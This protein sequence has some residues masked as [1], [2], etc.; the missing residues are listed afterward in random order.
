MTIDEVRKKLEEFPGDYK[1]A[2]IRDED[3]MVFIPNSI[4]CEDESKTVWM[5]ISEY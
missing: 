2:C 4:E 3:C 5:E 1:L